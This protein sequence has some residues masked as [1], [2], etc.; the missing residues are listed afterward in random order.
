MKTGQELSMTVLDKRPPRSAQV[1][2]PARRVRSRTRST[3]SLRTPPRPQAREQQRLIVQGVKKP[4]KNRMAVKGVSIDLR[5]G[6]PV[7][8]PGPNGAGKTT[9]FYTI[10]GII[11]PD[12]GRITIDGC[13]VSRLPMY[14]RARLGAGYPPREAFLSKTPVTVRL[15]ESTINADTMTPHWG[16]QYAVFEG[17][18]R[19]HIER[20]PAQAL[21]GQPAGQGNGAGSAAPGK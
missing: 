8:L 12:E 5:P 3:A 14:R 17:K 11:K 15:H 9:V 19:T 7:G 6:E 21:P 20:Q 1:R 13:D 4:F 18:V 2:Q 10:A 16:G